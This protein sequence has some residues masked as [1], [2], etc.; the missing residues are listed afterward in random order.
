V[1]AATGALLLSGLSFWGIHKSPRLTAALGIALAFVV[2][3]VALRA[4]FSA[5]GSFGLGHAR[6]D[7]R[8]RTPKDL[9]NRP[10]SRL[11]APP[12]HS[13]SY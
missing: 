10:D 6:R 13:S 4:A 9:Q 12:F 11:E 8:H 2:I 7:V 3:L 5:L 1:F